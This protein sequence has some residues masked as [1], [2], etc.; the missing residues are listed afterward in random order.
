[1][2]PEKLL[3]DPYAKALSGDVDWAEVLF[4]YWFDAPAE[5]NDDDS[6]GHVP[7]SLVVNPFF[8]WGSDLPPGTH[9][10]ESV[11]YEAHVKGMTA[12]HP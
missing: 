3:I 1:M 6:A 11:I 7:Y 10:H 8:D 9:Y 4:G 12:R 2:Q 5:R